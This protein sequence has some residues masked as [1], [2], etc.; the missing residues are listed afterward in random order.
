[1]RAF[2]APDESRSWLTANDRI[3]GAAL[4]RTHSP[5][6]GRATSR[7]DSRRQ[8]ASSRRIIRRIPHQPSSTRPGRELTNENATIRSRPRCSA[9]TFFRFIDLPRVCISQAC[10]RS[11]PRHATRFYDE[12]SFIRDE[13][14]GDCYE[15][16]TCVDSIQWNRERKERKKERKKRISFFFLSNR[17]ESYRNG[18]RYCKIDRIF[19]PILKE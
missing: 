7:A 13:S 14:Y 9:S 4:V 10:A 1:M 16:F 3:R 15:F 2:P 19:L 12:R 17:D 8:T 6:L 18:E 5:P 11:T